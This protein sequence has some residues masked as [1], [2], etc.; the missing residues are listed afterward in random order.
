MCRGSETLFPVGGTESYQQ[1]YCRS[2]AGDVTEDKAED[3]GMAKD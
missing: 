2:K 1:F 3:V